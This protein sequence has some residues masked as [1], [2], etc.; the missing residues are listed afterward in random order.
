MAEAETGP[1]AF[2]YFQQLYHNSQPYEIYE[3][4]PF[5]EFEFAQ[6]V[7][8]RRIF[9]NFIANRYIVVPVMMT[10]QEM[11]AIHPGQPFQL[12]IDY[13]ETDL[14]FVQLLMGVNAYLE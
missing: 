2:G 14:F 3:N 5:R 6:F 7:E 10:T 12:A 1:V 13:I 11:R 4:H 8:Q 9:S